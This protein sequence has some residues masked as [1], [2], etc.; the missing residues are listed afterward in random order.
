MNPLAMMTAGGQ[1]I[2]ILWFSKLSQH[3]VELTVQTIICGPNLSVSLAL[4]NPIQKW[5][6]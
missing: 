6:F 1:I 2:G 3:I 5:E 4:R